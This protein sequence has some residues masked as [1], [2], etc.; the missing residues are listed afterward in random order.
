MVGNRIGCALVGRSVR[1]TKMQGVGNDFVVIDAAGFHGD[2]AELATRVCGRRFGVGGDGLLVVSRVPSRS[3]PTF[4]FQLST[5][6]STLFSFR[7][8]NPDGSEDMCGNGLRCASLWAHGRGWLKGATHF[9]VDTKEGPR[10]VRLIDVA[11]DGLSGM[12]EVDMGVPR[13]SAREIPVCS[14][15]EPDPRAMLAARCS[16]YLCPDDVVREYPLALGD[17]VFNI[18]SVNTGSTH[19]LIFGPQPSDADFFHYG[20]LIEH[21]S[22]FPERTSVL[23]ATPTPNPSLKGRESGSL[24]APPLAIETRIWERGAG[25]TLGCGT[26]ACAVAVAARQLGLAAPGQPVDVVS[27]GGVLRIEWEG[28]ETPVRMSGPAVIVFEG[29]LSLE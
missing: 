16:S 29:A 25:E 24:S 20:P 27:R 14:C 13:F 8:F 18:T 3:D 9:T 1:F 26:G 17:R 5:F 2:P 23:W 11:G 15:D 12:F 22:F 6:N 7:M 28:S 10:S 19:T 21:H 4:N